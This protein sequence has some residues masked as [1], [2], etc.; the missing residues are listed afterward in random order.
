MAV[1]IK[2]I[3]EQSPAQNAGLK[4]G[5][6]LCSI[7]DNPINDGLDYEFYSAAKNPVV[8]AGFEGDA[9]A[10]Y[11]TKEEYEPLGCQFESYLIDETHRCKNSC[12]FCFIDQ[13]PK[14]MRESLYVKDD[15]ERM[16][17][18]FGNYIT[19]TNL[20][21]REVERIIDMRFS[22]VNISVHTQDPALRVQM[23][24]NP[25]A[26]KALEIIPVLAAAGI[27]MNFQLVLVPGVNDGEELRK[28]ITWLAGFAPHTQSIAAVPVGIT[29]HRQKLCHIKPY[30][31]ENAKTQLEIMLTEGEN[32]L[33]KTGKRLVYPADEWFLLAGRDIPRASFYD[34]YPQIENGVGMW[35]SFE[36]DFYEALKNNKQWPKKAEADIVVGTLVAPL[37]YK[38]AELLRK[39]NKNYVLHVHSVINHFFGESITVTGLLTGGDIARQLADEVASGRL[40]LPANVLRAQGDVMLDNMTPQQLG[41]KLNAKVQVVKQDADLL[42]DAILG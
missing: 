32:L 6:L 21:Q 10:F 13:M 41:Q 9:K 38:F 17:F 36:D 7:N 11:I 25:N 35:R 1:A 28:T 20:S 31:S 39:K 12:M 23:M 14:G 16:G 3:L 19:L 4:A 18:L 22:P 15:D 8:V 2:S 30:T 33:A 34:G 24:K 37:F 40:L 26:G 5:M 27:A 29:K 42:L